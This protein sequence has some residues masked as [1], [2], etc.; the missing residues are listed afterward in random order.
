V[1][2]VDGWAAWDGKNEKGEDSPPGRY[3]VIFSKDGNFLK[4]DF[5]DQVS[6]EPVSGC[7]GAVNLNRCLKTMG[8]IMAGIAIA[9][10]GVTLFLYR[11][12]VQ[13]LPIPG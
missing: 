10:L 1:A 7:L 12:H 2:A 4:K 13:P 6:S 5:F 11:G 9:L 3:Y 8:N